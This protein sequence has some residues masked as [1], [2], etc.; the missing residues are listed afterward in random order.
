MV[1][2]VVSDAALLAGRGRVALSAAPQPHEGSH[3]WFWLTRVR[4]S[5]DNTSSSSS[6]S[7]DESPQVAVAVDAFDGRTEA[8]LHL[9]RGSYATL[10][11]AGQPSTLLHHAVDA[12]SEELRV[13]MAP[14][15]DATAKPTAERVVLWNRSRRYHR[16]TA[17]DDALACPV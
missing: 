14:L 1:V 3:T 2:V 9:D 6:S 10:A 8:V 4:Q 5:H 12:S 17:A 7:T 11:A 15:D 16:T 13:E